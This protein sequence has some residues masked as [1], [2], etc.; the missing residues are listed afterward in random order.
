MIDRR[1]D[2]TAWTMHFVHKRNMLNDPAYELNKGSDTPLFAF[3]TDRE[4]N[5]RFD[6]WNMVEDSHALAADEDAFGV[7][8]KIIEDGH[9]RSGWSFRGSKP[10]IYGP[11][12]AT[13]L[14]EM[15]LYALL[16][17]AK[18]RSPDDV[19]TYAI[20]LLRD[21]LFAAGGRPSFMD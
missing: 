11:R 13:C 19:G 8:L 12:S 3:T 10:T 21:E 4:K 5:N 9:I 15:P 6:W 18:T 2:L 17:Y 14:T 16:E 7:L 20:C 1:H